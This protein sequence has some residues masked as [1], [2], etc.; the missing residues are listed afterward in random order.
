MY[1]PVR[2]IEVFLWGRRVGAL[3]HDYD[4]YSVFEYDPEFQRSGLEVA[5]FKMPL[6]QSVYHAEEF[7]L[8]RSMFFGLP[9]MIADS[10]PDAFGNALV[11]RYL[12]SEQIDPRQITPLDR[13]AYVGSRGIGALTFRPA[14][15][16]EDLVPSAI[17]MRTLVEES[18][19]ALN[20]RLSE[21]SG[22]DML[23]EIIR[24]GT[25]AGG[26]Q[27]K[28]V[29]GWNRETGQFLAGAGDLP[30]GFEHW[31]VKF[32]PPGLD[33]A[34]EREY[35]IYRKAVA[36][37]IRM[38]ECRLFELD[39]R[40][41]FMTKRFDREGNRRL[42]QQTLCALQHV[43]PASSSSEKC[44]EL[45]FRTIVDLG[46]DY[47]TREQ[48]FRRMAFN[49]LIGEIDDHTKNFSFLMRENGVWELA[50][51]YDL[52]G[53]HFSAADHAFDSWTNSHAL[54]VNGRVSGIR[55]EDLLAV[56]EKF[57]IG[58]APRLLAEVKDAVGQTVSPL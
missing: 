29:V 43:G 5:P 28:A 11:Q 9:G 33:D 49:V 3:A 35:A 38:S 27:A 46:L 16:D 41:H 55:D 52:T 58:T 53:C 23:R 26:A 18:R 30:D 40:R 54:S 45:L 15:R 14:L 36:A 20:G 2:V 39:G 17:D 21:M 50:P 4:R 44:Y 19:R 12:E 13:L 56:A 8:P 34:G 22:A 31:L 6:S 47:E 37:G 48:M 7:R 42:H 51:A 57:G 32:T 24:V 25:S 10:L 1:K